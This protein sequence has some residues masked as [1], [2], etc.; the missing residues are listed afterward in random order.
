MRRA[1]CLAHVQGRQPRT[2]SAAEKPPSPITMRTSEA[3]SFPVSDS[4]TA[5]P[6]M[7]NGPS[8][9]KKARKKEGGRTSQDKGA[10]RHK[11]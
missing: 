1:G 6:G 4:T 7:Y 2:V 10:R 9:R 11:W 5:V 3:V 8:C